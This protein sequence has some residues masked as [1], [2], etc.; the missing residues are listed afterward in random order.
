MN[1]AVEDTIKWPRF[2]RGDLHV[3]LA[4]KAH[5]VMLMI[6]GDTRALMMLYMAN[7]GI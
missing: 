1:T 3:Q 2:S 6:F 7:L 5:S 4:F